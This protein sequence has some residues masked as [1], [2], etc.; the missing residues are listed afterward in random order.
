MAMPTEAPIITRLPSIAI[1]LRQRFRSHPQGQLRSASSR[2]AS[3]PEST[4]WNSSPPSRPT[5]PRCAD[6]VIRSRCATCL[7]NWHRRPGAPCVS[8]TCLKRSRSIS[9]T[10]TTARW[11]LMR[12][13]EDLLQ[14]LR[15]LKKRFGEPGQRIDNAPAARRAVL[16]A[17]SFG[18]IGCP[19]RE[20]PEEIGETV[21]DRP[22][23][24]STTSVPHRMIGG[25]DQQVAG[26]STSAN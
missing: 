16:R 20:K 6:T 11:V 13:V 21:I 9:N 19:S 24:K 8:L 18:E 26:S 10:A 25:T 1:G 2:A 12:G 4:I 7:S 5:R 15:H 23:R 14:G 22:A 17:A 3:A